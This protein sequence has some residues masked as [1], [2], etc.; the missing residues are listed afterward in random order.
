MK[1]ITAVFAML[2]ALASVGEAQ[3]AQDPALFQ[4]EMNAAQVKSYITGSKFLPLSINT[5]NSFNNAREKA[6]VVAVAREQITRNGNYLAY[7]NAAV[8]YAVQSEPYGLDEFVPL[9]VHD[10]AN[11]IANATKAIELSPNTPYMYYLRGDVYMD[12]GTEPIVPTGELQI[13]SHD[14]ARKALADYEKVAELKPSIAPYGHMASLARALRMTEK[15]N[16]YEQ[17][18]LAQQRAMEQ[19]AADRSSRQQQTQRSVRR[20]VEEHNRQIQNNFWSNWSLFK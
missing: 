13:K 10:A 14:Y 9:D 11:A 6:D 3:S 8:V 15:A 1:K 2:L 17:R 18:S 12:Q 7:Y 5:N 16:K 4:G 19:A 20:G